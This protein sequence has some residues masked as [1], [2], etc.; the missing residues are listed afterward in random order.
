[1]NETQTSVTQWRGIELTM[2]YAPHNGMITL[3]DDQGN[4]E[5]YVGYTKDEAV[6]SFVAAY[7]PIEYNRVLN[8]NNKQ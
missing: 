1:M 3:K 5:K 2:E 6:R 8:V 7:H 4:R